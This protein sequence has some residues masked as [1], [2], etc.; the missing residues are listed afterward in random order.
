MGTFKKYIEGLQEQ[1]DVVTR[2]LTKLHYRGVSPDV[3]AQSNL[4]Y[5]M[6][7][8]N[9]NQIM[10]DNDINTARFASMLKLKA[11]L[12]GTGDVVNP[13]NHKGDY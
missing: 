3:I 11:R 7:I 6:N 2:A 4:Q 13:Q 12:M 1:E 5:I 9:Q 8:L 10:T